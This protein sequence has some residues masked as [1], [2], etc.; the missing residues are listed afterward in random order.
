MRNRQLSVSA[1]VRY[2]KG[3]LDQ[4]PLIQ[5]VIVAGEI[6][7]FTAHRQRSLVFHIKG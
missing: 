2:L 6:S 3:K 7:N 4:D 1:L 5:R